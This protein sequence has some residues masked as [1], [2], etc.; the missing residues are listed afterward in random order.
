[1]KKKLII[2][3]VVGVVVA[4]IVVANL[5]RSHEPA[6]EVDSAK[7][8]VG[9]IV[10]KVR[11]PGRVKPVTEVKVSANVVGQIVELDV[12]EGDHVTVA[13]Q[14]L[15]LDD[16]QYRAQVD[17]MRAQ[18]K[19]AREQ[20]DQSRRRL[21][22]ARSLLKKNLA[23]EEEV[24]RLETEEKVA[25]AR[26]AQ[27]KA[28]LSSA[29]DNLRKTVFVSPIDGVVSRLNVEVGENVITGTMNNPGTVIMTLA[30]LS[31]MEVVADV[32]ETDVVDI[33]YG[34]R[35]EIRVDAFPDTV[36]TGEI[37]EIASSASIVMAGA[38]EEQTNFQVKVLVSGNPTGL[39]PGMTAQTIIETA[40]KDS[41]MYVPIQAVVSR[42][43]ED[44]EAKE[45]GKPAA[46][47]DSLAAGPA[48][49]G[50]G[51]KKELTGV[52]LIKDKRAEFVPVTPGISSETDIEVSGE[53]NVGDEIVSGPYKALR[54]LKP[55][56]KLK[57]VKR[58]SERKR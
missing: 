56:E 54:T 3:A 11:A 28:A 43:P 12:E 39:R 46:P 30:D 4:G 55:G 36:F 58:T 37:A 5:R 35:V 40:R 38:G 8:K 53:L 29:E 24:E 1:M 15:R 13:Q 57:I 52:F 25:R 41:V 18:V 2:I 14:L 9:E 16:T 47:S 33:G 44:L 20:L 49:K 50:A 48:G 27:F 6:V 7:V 19:E 42:S 34:Q 17:R 26:L 45:A 32:D 22:R 31:K 23:S 10:S 51:R 21:D